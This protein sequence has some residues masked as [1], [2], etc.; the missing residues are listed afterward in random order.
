[1]GCVQSNPKSQTSDKNEKNKT[2]LESKGTKK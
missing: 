1:M 2:I